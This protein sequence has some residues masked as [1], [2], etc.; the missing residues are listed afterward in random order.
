MDERMIAVVTGASS[1]IG[2][3]TARLLAASGHTVYGGARGRRGGG[4][5]EP[6][7]KA[8]ALD[9]DD[10]ASVDEAV[11]GVLGA[12]GRVD[13]LV[14]CAGYAQ[15]G[16]VEDLTID[17]IKRNME[18]NYVGTVRMIKAVVPAMRRRG[19]G[20]IV[21]V[22]AVAGRMGF[23]LTSAYVAS[24]FAVEGLTESLRHELRRFGILVSAV[25]PGVVRTAFHGNMKLPRESSESPYWDMT[26]QLASKSAVLYRRGT[27]AGV[28]A[29][30]ILGALSD[31][32]PAQRYAAGDDARTLVEERARRSDAEFEGYVQDIFGD[33]MGLES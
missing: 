29:R 2:L 24:K 22:S 30:T 12:E 1:G 10:Q 21:N 23:P 4:A 33:V 14:N 28:V 16:A 25:E 18:T 15:I 9:V 7:V 27:D 3:E 31:P 20:R 26:V 17:D 13:A 19:G 6:H 32:D 8:M 5:A 11:G